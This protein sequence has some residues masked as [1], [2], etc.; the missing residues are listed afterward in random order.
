MDAGGMN[1][2]SQSIWGGKSSNRRISMRLRFCV[3]K[4]K[5]KKTRKLPNSLITAK[6]IRFP[7]SHFLS[8][9]RTKAKIRFWRVFIFGMAQRAQIIPKSEHLIWWN[10]EMKMLSSHFVHCFW[11][12]ADYVYWYGLPLYLHSSVE[13][14][15]CG[16]WCLC[17]LLLTFSFPLFSISCT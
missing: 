8:K 17:F 1:A 9:K 11:F 13:F 2:G 14:I 16:E 7:N 6:R 3:K 5:I 15:V 12:D 4:R 10:Y